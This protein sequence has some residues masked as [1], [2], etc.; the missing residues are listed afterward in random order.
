MQHIVHPDAVKRQTDEKSDKDC[1]LAVD[2]L[3]LAV[4]AGARHPQPRTA[5]QLTA[6]AETMWKWVT[7]D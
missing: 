2:V 3:R 1:Q 6:D 7:S 4:E 5:E